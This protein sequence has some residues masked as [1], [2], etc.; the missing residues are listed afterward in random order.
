MKMGLII[1]A[2]ICFALAVFGV[3]P[4]GLQPVPLGLGL[5]CLSTVVS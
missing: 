3:A 5:W 2:C 4:G 1:G